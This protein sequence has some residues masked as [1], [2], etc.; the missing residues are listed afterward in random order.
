MLNRR[1]RNANRGGFPVKYACSGQSGSRSLVKQV[2]LVTP[3]DF[4]LSD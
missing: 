4:H 3:I 2:S 1:I